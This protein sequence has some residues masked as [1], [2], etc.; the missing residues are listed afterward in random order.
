[1]FSLWHKQSGENS[2]CLLHTAYTRY[3][4]HDGKALA[5]N[6][7]FNSV[8]ILNVDFSLLAKVVLEDA[9]GRPTGSH[10]VGGLRISANRYERDRDMV[11][12]MLQDA[13]SRYA[14]IQHG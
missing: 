6:I 3:S 13:E 9:L 7:H 2:L 8:R 14:L 5:R 11:I 4:R 12:V 10:C 1:V